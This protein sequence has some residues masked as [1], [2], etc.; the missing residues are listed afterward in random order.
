M[1]ESVLL[2]L[3]E[4]QDE[5]GN[6]YFVSWKPKQLPILFTLGYDFRLEENK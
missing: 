5:R 2:S 6:T 1:V 3:M 4:F